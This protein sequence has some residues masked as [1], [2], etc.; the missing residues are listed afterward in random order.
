[1]RAVGIGRIAQ[2]PK[3]FKVYWVHL[4]LGAFSAPLYSALLVVGISL[5]RHPAVDFS[6]LLVYRA[7][8]GLTVSSLCAAFSGTDDRTRQFQRLFLLPQEL[9]L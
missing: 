1:L 6:A 5:D 7:L 8:C 4:L 2:H 3:E 9:D